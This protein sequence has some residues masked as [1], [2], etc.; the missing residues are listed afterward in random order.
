[1]SFQTVLTWASFILF[2]CPR[3]L[4]CSPS[5][6]SGS[7]SPHSKVRDVSSQ[8]LLLNSKNTEDRLVFFW[9]LDL[10][11][12]TPKDRRTEEVFLQLDQLLTWWR[13]HISC[14]CSWLYSNYSLYIIFYSKTQYDNPV[15]YYPLNIFLFFFIVC[16]D[17][18]IY[19]HTIQNK[20]IIHILL[21]IYCVKN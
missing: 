19:I 2:P 5:C 13:H 1:M 8:Q 7:V 3:P 10:G 15:L 18:F 11:V 6:M 21:Y 20:I 4:T 12:Q 9:S 17:I 16:V 14:S